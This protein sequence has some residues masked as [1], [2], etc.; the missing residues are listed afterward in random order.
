MRQ[1]ELLSRL[2]NY[3]KN[4]YGYPFRYSLWLVKQIERYKSRFC[5]W[6]AEENIADYGCYQETDSAAAQTVL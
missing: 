4:E 5:P 2:G 1:A 3:G 6:V